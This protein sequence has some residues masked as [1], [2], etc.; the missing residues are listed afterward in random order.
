MKITVELNDADFEGTLGQD[1]VKF[2]GL[3]ILGAQMPLATTTA[4]KVTLPDTGFQAPKQ[5]APKQE[6]YKPYNKSGKL[7]TLQMIRELI[8]QVSGKHGDAGKSRVKAKLTELGAQ[9]ASTLD[10]S[11]YE[12]MYSFLESFEQ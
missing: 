10:I 3:L 1:R 11:K 2:L 8:G 5:E 7:I 9:N 12:E 4:E 6:E